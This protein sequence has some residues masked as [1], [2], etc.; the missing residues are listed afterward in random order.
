MA[1]YE[2]DLRNLAGALLPNLLLDPEFLIFRDGTEVAPV[3]VPMSKDQVDQMEEIM[4]NNTE[5]TQLMRKTNANQKRLVAHNDML[6]WDLNHNRVD[7]ERMQAEN[8]RRR[9]ALSYMKVSK[10]FSSCHVITETL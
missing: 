6:K 5:M 7:L 8:K 1:E 2:Q 10:R 9:D 3:F 4:Y